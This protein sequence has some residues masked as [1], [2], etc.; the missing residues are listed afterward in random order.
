MLETA[1]A[2]S[3]EEDIEIWATAGCTGGTSEAPLLPEDNQDCPPTDTTVACICDIVGNWGNAL[4]LFCVRPKEDG[5][6]A[7][8]AE[9]GIPEVP[10]PCI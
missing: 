2:E 5:A 4:A 8:G 7:Y 6:K 1:I 3:E 10:T 9:I